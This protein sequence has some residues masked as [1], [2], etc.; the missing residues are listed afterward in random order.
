ML[1]CTRQPI[2]ASTIATSGR[3]YGPTGDVVAVAREIEG[4]RAGN[5]GR[6]GSIDDPL[7]GRE[8]ARIEQAILKGNI[9]VLEEYGD[10]QG[11]LKRI[12]ALKKQAHK[13]GGRRLIYRGSTW[14]TE[15]L[16][17]VLFR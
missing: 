9:R 17:E 14:K 10:L 8:I 13:Q 2:A 7:A 1:P 15:H 11:A 12:V 3:R 4:P 6:G 5:F 16:S